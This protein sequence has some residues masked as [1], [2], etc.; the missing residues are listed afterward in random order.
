MGGVADRA[1]VGVGGRH[2]RIM[3]RA[4]L[5]VSP[6]LDVAAACEGLK[7]HP[8]PGCVGAAILGFGRA[9]LDLASNKE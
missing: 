7:R 2:R 1:R 9:T 6:A 4:R 8:K 3:P 5:G